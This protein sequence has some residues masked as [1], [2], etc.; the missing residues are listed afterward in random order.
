[1]RY[2]AAVLLASIVWTIPSPASAQPKKKFDPIEIRKIHVGYRMYKEED[3]SAYK[4]GLWTPIYIEVYGGADGVEKKV[5]DKEAPYLEITTNDSEDVGTTIPLGPI[6]VEPLKSRT[7]I[8]YVKTGHYSGGNNREISV[9]LQIWNRNPIKPLPYDP[10]LNVNIDAHLYL[11][12]GPRIEDFHAAVK[13]LGQGQ[14][15]QGAGRL[16]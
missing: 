13:K 9:A 4:A 16:S 5:T 2:L 10:P 6:S 1:M 14:Q 12:L 15:R 11:T 7:F 3:Q 8:G